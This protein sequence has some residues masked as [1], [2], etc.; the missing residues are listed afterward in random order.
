MRRLICLV[1]ILPA[2]STLAWADNPCTNGS[3]EQLSPNG[4]PVDWSA[5]GTQVEVVSQ[6]HSGERGLRLV[7][8]AS[9]TSLET[10]L[11][12]THRAD[13]SGGGAMIE[14]R[15]GGLEFWYQAVSAEDAELCVYAIPMDAEGVER[16]GSMRA[17]FVVPTS[18]IGDHQWHQGRLKYDFTDNPQVRW[19]QFAPRIVGVA[20]EMILD[21]FTYVEQV[22][23]IL[24]VGTIQ[25][26]EDPTR[27][28]QRGIVRARIENVGDSDAEAVR[29]V[30]EPPEGLSVDSPQVQ[31]DRLPVDHAERV[32]WVLAGARQKPQ[33]LHVT[34]RCGDVDAE[35]TLAL[36]VG[37]QIRSFGPEQPVAAAD[38][39]MTVECVLEN[40]GQT[41]V[42]G[43]D[44]EFTLASQTEAKSVSSLAPG[45]TAVVRARF[46]PAE[47]SPGVPVAVKVDCSTIGQSLTADSQVVVASP[48]DLPA[49]H[50]GL[51]AA[52]D[53]RFAFLCNR[54]VRLAFRRNAFGFGPGEL[55]IAQGAGWQTV[56]WLPRM[57]RLVCQDHTGATI[58]QD[59]LIDSQPEVIGS[60]PKQLCFRWQHHDADG[61]TW[62]ATITF[63]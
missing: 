30:L 4:F 20:G 11:N 56:A 32:E 42:G 46:Q 26:E 23:V 36:Q 37:F 13:A 43:I 54:F 50:A 53:E 3:F 33:S 6:S 17:K 52:S 28:G 31:L 16:T 19:V 38:K 15:R 57:S 58:E 18:H 48:L 39:P 45:R 7:R 24:H 8:S 14:P 1:V 21:D 63:E 9:S 62:N 5:I 55:S 25:I 51:N 35:G 60:D 47:Q 10:G 59:V 22:G 40:T 27:P 61:A 34:A 2:V 49:E 41:M 29:V 12:R 44:C